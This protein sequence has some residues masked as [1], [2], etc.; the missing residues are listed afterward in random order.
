MFKDHLAAD[1]AC[2]INL[3]EFADSHSING[4]EVPAIIDDNNDRQFQPS[5]NGP[6]GQG[7]YLGDKVLFVKQSD[8]GYVPAIDGVLDLDGNINTVVKVSKVGGILAITLEA[9]E[10]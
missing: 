3:D 1:L 4:K 7:L 9:N 6:P 5:S 10:E 2:F 8:L